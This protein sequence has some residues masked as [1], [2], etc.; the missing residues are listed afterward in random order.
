MINIIEKLRQWKAQN[1]AV[2]ALNQMDERM[3]NDIGIRRADIPR[4][5]RGLK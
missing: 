4:Y 1:V 5:V 3:L 2:S